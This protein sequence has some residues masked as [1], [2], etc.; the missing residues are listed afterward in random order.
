[1][2]RNRK[3]NIRREKIIMITSSAFVLAALTM[4]GLY[5]KGQELK[6]KDDGYTLDFTALENQQDNSADDKLAEI[7][8]H[9]GGTD[10]NKTDAGNGTET[11]GNGNLQSSVTDILNNDLDYMPPENELSAEAGS[12]LI[13]IPGL[14][15]GTVLGETKK[16]ETD[17]TKES[18]KEPAKESAKETAGQGEAEGQSLHYNPEQG[19][20]KPVEG[21][22]LLPYSMDGSIYFATLD[23]YRYNPATIFGAEEGAAVVSCADGRVKEVKQ[24]AQLGQVVIL[25]LGDGYQVT[26][27]QLNELQVASGDYVKAGAKLGTVAAPSKYYSKEGTNLYFAL[28]KDGS[29]VNAENLF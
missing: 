26:Y 7:G 24:D 12:N 29:P 25:E 10:Q 20:T 21:E 16:P 13:E 22:I 14:T 4:T 9:A 8:K 17:S 5:M 15:D 27:G 3:S 18:S 6:Q 19:M 23:Q 1:M 28:S 2:R 11:I